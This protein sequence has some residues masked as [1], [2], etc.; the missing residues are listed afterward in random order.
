MIYQPLTEEDR[1]TLV[2]EAKRL[3]YMA[4]LYRIKKAIA[5]L[6]RKDHSVA[7]VLFTSHGT[8]S[9]EII[10]M[11]WMMADKLSV[12]ITSFILRW[13]E[14]SDKLINEME[15]TTCTSQAE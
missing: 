12:G 10:I 8:L 14:T 6:I 5:F 2:T 11:H 13:K 3:H 15:Q 9:P 4:T 1:K 7:D